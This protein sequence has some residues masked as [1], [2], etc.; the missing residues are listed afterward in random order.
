[1]I[2]EILLIT[3]M[4][5]SCPKTQVINNTSKWTKTD[6]EVLKNSKNKCK[7]EYKDALCLKKFIKQ[8]EGIYAVICGDTH[9]SN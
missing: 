4:T 5:S 2:Q 9:V 3:M 8:D 1:M 7:T 6:D